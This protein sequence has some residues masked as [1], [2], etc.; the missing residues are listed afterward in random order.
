M[1]LDFEP[2]ICPGYRMR[3]YLHGAA[4]GDVDQFQPEKVKVTSSLEGI[5]RKL[6]E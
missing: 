3:V 4:F 5:S 1:R 6:G 2:R